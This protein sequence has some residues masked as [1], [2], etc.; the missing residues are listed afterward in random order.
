MSF[1]IFLD[2][3]IFYQLF[4]SQQVKQCV[5]ITYF[6][7]IY[8]LP[9]K[10]R[11]DLRLRILGNQ[12]ISGN[13]LNCIEWEPSVQSPDQN[14]C[15]CYNQKKTLE[16]QKLNFSRCALFHMKTRVSLRYFV[17][18]CVSKHFFD[19]KSPQTTS[20]LFSLTVSVT[21]RPSKLF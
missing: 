2:F 1:I 20:N 12:V 8:E 17:S 7:G 19:S 10:L 9:H 16:K 6:Y 21:L 14:K 15:F 4:F 18:Y 13:C 3:W 5:I 11:N